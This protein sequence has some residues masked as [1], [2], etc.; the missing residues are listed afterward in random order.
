MRVTATGP[1]G[2]AT[3]AADFAV[4]AVPYAAL[5]H[6]R[7]TPALSRGK[8]RVVRQLR[9]T[10]V[11]RGLVQCRDRFWEGIDASGTVFT[12]IPGM[13]V[14][15]G[16]SRPSRR[17]ILE[18]YFSGS[19]ARR[20]SRMTPARRNHTIV[21]L[22]TRVFRALPGHVEAVVTQCWDRDPWARGGYA[23]YAPGQIVSF[24]PD[25]ARPDGRLHFAGDHT[26]LGPGWIEGAIASGERVAAEIADRR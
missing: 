14:F 2:A 17:G 9:N 13:T 7:I 22:M 20:L 6:I 11:L 3:I 12:D 15:S 25:L 4:V 26:S 19:A 10:S 21:G 16:Y 5:R 8:R 18:A 1:G 23:W 24:M